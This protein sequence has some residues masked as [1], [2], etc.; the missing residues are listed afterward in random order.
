M[1]R[2]AMTCKTLYDYDLLKTKESLRQYKKR[3]DTP[4][5]IIGVGWFQKSLIALDMLDT[6]II[7]N[8]YI[9]NLIHNTAQSLSYLYM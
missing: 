4:K 9:S 8:D 7:G 3:F 5:I 2:L 6:K 1:E